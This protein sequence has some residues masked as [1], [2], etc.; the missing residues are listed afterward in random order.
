MNY[1]ENGGA[2]EIKD[3][4]IYVKPQDNKAYYVVNG[5]KEGSVDLV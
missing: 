5:E 1:K 4:K 3:V 2:A